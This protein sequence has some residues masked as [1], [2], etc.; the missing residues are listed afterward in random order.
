M[1]TYQTDSIQVPYE[2]K[3]W[4]KKSSLNLRK[5]LTSKAMF[6]LSDISDAHARVKSGA[7][8]QQYALDLIA[9]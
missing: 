1:K 9:M 4:Q 8:F 5:S 6:T 7:D 3:K 2:V